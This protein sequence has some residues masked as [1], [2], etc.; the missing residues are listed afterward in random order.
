MLFQRAQ[1]DIEVKEGPDLL[2][3]ACPYFNGQMCSHPKGEE[4]EVRKWD[5]R[6]LEGL[7]LDFGQ[8]LKVEYVKSLIREKTPLEFCL[9]KCP[10]YREKKCD[11][12][13]LPPSL[14]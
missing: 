3:E 1:D 5:I 7:G 11:P 10:Y 4:K 6:I 2:C 9:V 12:R 13:V 8:V 14:E